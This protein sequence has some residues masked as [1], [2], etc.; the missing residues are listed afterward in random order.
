[1]DSKAECGQL[2][3]ACTRSQKQKSMKEK[4]K[5]INASAHYRLRSE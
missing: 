3:V 4:L 1:M 2:N 5:Q